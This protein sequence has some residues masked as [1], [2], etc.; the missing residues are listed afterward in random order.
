MENNRHFISLQNMLNSIDDSSITDDFR[1]SCEV[2]DLIFDATEESIENAK[3]LIKENPK[4]FSPFY[5]Q[6]MILHVSTVRRFSF[7][8]LASLWKEIPKTNKK[9]QYSIFSDFL[10]KEGLIQNDNILWSPTEKTSQDILN[11]FD[12]NSI[13]HSVVVDDLEKFNEKIVSY[14]P[15]KYTIEIAS[16]TGKMNLYFIDFAALCGS[17]KIFKALLIDGCRL[18]KQTAECVIKGGNL[19][20]LEILQQQG[21]YFHNFFELAI[22]YHRND[23][24]YWLYENFKHETKVDLLTC[25]KSFNTS[26]IPFII[27]IGANLEIKDEDKRSL[28]HLATMNDNIQ[29]IKY[30]IDEGCNLETQ[31][32]HFSTPLIEASKD[33]FLDIVNLYLEHGCNI[34]A[35]DYC[36]Q[37]SLIWASKCGYF[38]IVQVLLSHGANRQMKDNYG[39]S[40]YDLSFNHDIQELLNSN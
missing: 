31:D 36:H 11:V 13:L 9:I 7:K 17:V 24:A 8:A 27:S 25:I 22:I 35:I 38:D 28:L 10:Y 16:Q 37:T 15:S 3:K 1:L 29:L 30:L 6:S 2:E 26:A 20:L 40:A 12:E 14:N 34:N 19:E 21:F 18:T 33:G 5:L 4:F 32:N 23:I 39:R